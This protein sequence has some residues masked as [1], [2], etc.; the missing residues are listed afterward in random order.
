MAPLDNDAAIAQALVMIGYRDAERKALNRI[1]DYVMG[2]QP[3]VSVPSGAP[4]EVRALA[5]IA[6]VNILQ[7]VVT[8]LTQALYVDGYRAPRSAEDA[9]AWEVWQAN[10]MDAAQ[11][12]VHRAALTYGTAYTSVTPGEPVPVIRGYS[13]R[14]MTTLYDP[15]EP[16][17]PVWALRSDRDGS[18]R[19]YDATSVYTLTGKGKSWE[20]AATDDHGVGHVPVVRF[21]NVQDLD[22]DNLGEVEPLIDLQ[23]QIDLT[24]FGLLVAQHY[25]AW[26]QRWILGWV[27]DTEAEL[28]KVSASRILTLADSPDD[29]KVGEFE[30]TDLAGYLDSRESSLRHAATISETPIHELTG[31][32]VNLSAEALVAAESGQR[33]KIVER[34]VSFGESWEQT[35][36][37]AGELNGT[38]ADDQAE[39]RWR[40]T[41]S[42]ALAATVDAL[43][44]M[45]SELGIPPSQLWERIPN[46][47]QQDIERWKAAAAEQAP[48][49]NLTSMLERNMGGGGGGN[50]NAA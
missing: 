24:T 28:T 10:A 22:E 44:K 49:A 17:W 16:Y 19:L 39:V 9:P 25:A 21:L 4:R 7:I 5:K 14:N 41:E 12:G 38:E 35:L 42:R 48:L 8:A 43:G 26:R 34:Q 50:Q 18:V 29:V 30:Q 2:K 3:P 1:H 47:S 33:R 23:D 46:T 6:R 31:A 37:L 45:A 11:I 15:D 20:V 36:A 32:L 13:P 40:D 27:A